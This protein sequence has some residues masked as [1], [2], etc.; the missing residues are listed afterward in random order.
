MTHKIRHELPFYIPPRRNTI[1]HYATLA[2][3]VK[4]H[5]SPPILRRQ[6]ALNVNQPASHTLY[7][8]TSVRAKAVGLIFTEEVANSSDSAVIRH[9]VLFPV[10]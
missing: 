5:R 2:C 6:V 8:R 1:P 10:F 4:R 9:L 3:V 7:A